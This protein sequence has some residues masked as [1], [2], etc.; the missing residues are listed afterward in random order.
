M[1]G[2]LAGYSTWRQFCELHGKSVESKEA[3]RKLKSSGDAE[4]VGDQLFV[5]TGTPWPLSNRGQNVFTRMRAFA[6]REKAA[7]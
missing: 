1:S 6:A 5:K 3:V 2:T 7:Q 4:R